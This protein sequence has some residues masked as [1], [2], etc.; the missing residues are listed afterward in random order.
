MLNKVTLPSYSKTEEKLN[1]VTHTIGILL[2]M[3]ITVYCICH[4]ET[5]NELWGS[6]T[7][8]M[9]LIILFFS[10]TM[11]HALKKENIKKIFRLIDHSAIFIVISGSTV[12]IS[13]ITVYQ[14]NRTAALITTGVD[15]LI[16][17]VGILMTFIDQEKFKNL[18]LVLYFS[19]A[20]TGFIIG[21][22]LIEIVNNGPIIANYIIGGGLIFGSGMILY[23]I[24]KKKK[25]FHTVFHVVVLVG[26]IVHFIA[27]YIAL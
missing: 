20:C 8:G 18:Q 10:S 9:S 7:Y 6:I 15:L 26:T 12:G 25:Y 17:L 3:A 24:G 21:D 16:V 5:T 22:P 27:F 2:G 19:L 14:F 23:L 4:S 1:T 11:Y 13:L